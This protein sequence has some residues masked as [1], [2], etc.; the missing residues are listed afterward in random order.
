MLFLTNRPECYLHCI[1]HC[2]KRKLDER[3]LPITLGDE[4]QVPRLFSP[5]FIIRELSR[6]PNAPNQLSLIF[7]EFR[8]SSFVCRN[9]VSLLGSSARI[10]FDVSLS[11]LCPLIGPRITRFTLV[12]TNEDFFNF[13]T[14]SARNST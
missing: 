5:I 7:I 13:A 8:A 6:G 3:K 9:K 11:R 1:K 2:R 4:Y 12:Q 14:T 10:S